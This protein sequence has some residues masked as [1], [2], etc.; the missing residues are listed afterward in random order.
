MSDEAENSPS[1]HASSHQ[2]GRIRLHEF[3]GG[4]TGAGLVLVF[5][6]GAALF[7]GIPWISQ[8]REVGL[9]IVAIFGIMILFGAMAL[10]STLFCRLGLSNPHEAL[11]LPQG[12]IRAAIALSLIVLFAIISIMLFQSMAKPYILYGLSLTDKNAIAN[13]AGNRVLAVVKVECPPVLA[14]SSTSSKPSLP[15]AGTPAPAAADSAPPVE[16]KP[17][18]GTQPPVATPPGATPASSPEFC[19]DLHLVQPP[20]QEA[21]DLAKQLLILIGTLM[22]SVTS[23]YFATQATVAAVKATAPP[24]TVEDK[25]NPV[26][27]TGGGAQNDPNREKSHPGTQSAESISPAPSNTPPR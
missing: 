4:A 2:A 9:P 5:L 26:T 22:T 15:G 14:R 8:A 11:A 10:V 6:P 24:N 13:N 27:P 25:K 21:F 12:S 18:S 19:Y 17:P 16:A 3:G 1:N 23:F 7:A 20:G